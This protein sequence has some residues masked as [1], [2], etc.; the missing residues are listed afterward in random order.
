MYTLD[1]GGIVIKWFSSY[2]TNRVQ[3]TKVKDSISGY[4]HACSGIPKGSV[5][6][7]LLFVIYINVISSKFPSQLTCSLFA[8][9]SNISL[10]Y[11][12]TTERNIL[13]SRLSDLYD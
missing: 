5:I 7:P 10:S 11:R 9:S 4:I 6:G 3:R 8:D 2:L 1:I 13:Q 12:N